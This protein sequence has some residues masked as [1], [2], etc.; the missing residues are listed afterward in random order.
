MLGECSIRELVASFEEAHLPLQPIE[1]VTLAGSLRTARA[2]TVGHTNRCYRGLGVLAVTR[3]RVDA[4][5]RWFEGEQRFGDDSAEALAGQ[6]ITE[7]ATGCAA[8]RERNNNL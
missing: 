1:R 4:R 6:R 2:R 5:E 3:L 8:S 7:V